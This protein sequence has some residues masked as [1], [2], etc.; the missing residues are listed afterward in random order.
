M[1]YLTDVR[2][3][4]SAHERGP[5]STAEQ[6][7]ATQRLHVWTSTGQRTAVALSGRGTPRLSQSG[8]RRHAQFAI[9]WERLPP[10][11]RRGSALRG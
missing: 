9:V 6:V 11:P 2:A 1:T 8:L 10:H 3:P 7:R 5:C 4:V